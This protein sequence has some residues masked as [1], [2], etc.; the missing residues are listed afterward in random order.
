MPDHTHDSYD[1]Y[2]VAEEHHLHRNLENQLE[3]LRIRI[4]ELEQALRE[5]QQAAPHAADTDT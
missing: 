1:V 3:A 2:G 4:G 5:H